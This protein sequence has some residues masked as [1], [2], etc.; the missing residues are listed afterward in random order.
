MTTTHLHP[1]PCGLPPPGLLA[2]W[3]FDTDRPL[4]LTSTGPVAA[5]LRPVGA[6]PTHVEGGPCGGALRFDGRHQ[7][8]VPRAELGPLNRCGDR[9]AVT[10]IAWLRRL[11]DSPWQFVAGVWDESRA[12]RQYGLFLNASAYPTGADHHRSPCRGR[13]HGHVSNHGGPTPGHRVCLTYATGATELGFDRWHTIAMTFDGT[14]SRVF[15][16][17]H[18]DCLTNANPLSFPHLLHDGGPDGADFAIGANSVAGETRNYLQADLAA[19]AIY[20]R[21]LSDIPASPPVDSTTSDQPKR[22]PSACW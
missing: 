14:C 17:G 1:A 3:R 2:L 10:V 21:A 9:S 20:D 15:V 13:V 8:I 5:R 6:M 16:D 11:G 12:Q 19:I 22:L 18:L 7:L 4:A